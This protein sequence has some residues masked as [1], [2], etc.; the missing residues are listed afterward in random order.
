MCH[1]QVSSPHTAGGV[2]FCHRVLGRLR[3]SH[4]CAAKARNL[5]LGPQYRL[6]HAACQVQEC[7]MGPCT[8]LPLLLSSIASL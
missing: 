3:A 5:P 8:A 1:F 6:T 4:C 7:L 2:P